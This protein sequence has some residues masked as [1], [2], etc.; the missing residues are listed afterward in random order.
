MIDLLTLA[1]F[2]AVIIYAVSYK[3]GRKW[4]VVAATST[5]LLLC[6]ASLACI[7]IVGDPPSPNDRA[8]TQQELN[9]AEK[10]SP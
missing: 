5:F 9:H 3:L 8:V 7:V 6:V 2:V 4:R 10:P 1:L